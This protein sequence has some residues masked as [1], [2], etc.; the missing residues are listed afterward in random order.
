MHLTLRE[1][2]FVLYLG[3]LVVSAICGVIAAIIHDKDHVL[4]VFPF[5]V[6]LT[7][8]HFHGK[9]KGYDTGAVIGVI[10]FGWLI[11]AVLPRKKTT[12]QQPVAPS[13]LVQPA[14]D[15]NSAMSAPEVPHAGS[16]ESNA[17]EAG[18]NLPSG[19]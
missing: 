9:S 15:V 12:I 16:K 7:A 5:A 17:Q 3:A 14:P 19:Y 2:A 1:K 8:T 4:M 18:S 6:Y 10:P 11:I 13:T